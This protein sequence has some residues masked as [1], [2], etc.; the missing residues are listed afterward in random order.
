MDE[1]TIRNF[2]KGYVSDECVQV[3]EPYAGSYISIVGDELMLNIVDDTVEVNKYLDDSRRFSFPYSSIP[4]HVEKNLLGKFN[5]VNQL[6]DFGK[7]YIVLKDGFVFENSVFKNDDNGEGILV[8]QKLHPIF[9]RN[10]QF[11]LS[12]TEL[13]DFMDS[14][15]SDDSII[16]SNYGTVVS[17]EKAYH[18][19]D[20]AYEASIV[21]VNPILDKSLVSGV[22]I[23]RN[24]KSFDVILFDFK[25]HDYSAEEALEYSKGAPY[26][27]EP[28]IK[29]R[30]N[31]SV[32]RDT[33]LRAKSMSNILNN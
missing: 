30:L 21:Y 23:Y 2:K 32:D 20:G 31:P 4:E 7:K 10:D 1:L 33:I 17:K 14:T 5:Y 15:I 25:A 12:F 8:R 22:K 26:Q 19:I 11:D 28:K 9:P 16:F 24:Q 27:R 29:R 18:T 3:M 13:T 6:Y